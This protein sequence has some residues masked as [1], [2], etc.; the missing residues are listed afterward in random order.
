MISEKKKIGSLLAL[1]LVFFTGLML[2]SEASFD[3]GDG[4]QH[5]VVSRF[6][7]LH[8]YLFLDSWGKPFY[9]LVS[10]PFAQF[11][12]KGS[13][14]FN[15]LCG[16]GSSYFAYLF[17]KKMEL[18]N[19]WLIIPIVLF[20]PGFFPTL[21][22]GLTEPFFSFLLMACAYGYVLKKYALSSLLISFLPFIR[23][24]GF[25]IIPLFAITLLLRKQ[26][27]TIVLLSFGTI[28]YSLIG[29]IFLNDFFWIIYQNPYNGGS[30]EIYGHG[31]WWH[32]ISNYNYL[33]G[34]ILSILLLAG[35]PALLKS[36]M[37][38]KQ[39]QP[40]SK[41][42]FLTEEILLLICSFLVYLIAHSIMWWKG[43]ANS[44][45]MLRVIAAVL[46]CTSLL[47]LRGF[48]LFYI[49]QFKKIKI[50]KYAILFI[51]FAVIVITPFKKEYFPFNLTPEQKVTSEA[52]KWIKDS[53]YYQNKIYFLDP[54]L[55]SLLDIDSFD[56][57]RSAPLWGLYSSIEKYGIKNIPDSTVVFWDSHY[58]P[59]ECRIPL[60]QLLTDQNFKHLKSF[61]PNDRFTTLGGYEYEINVFMKL[62]Q[63]A[64]LV[65]L[66]E[67][68]INF[69]TINENI[70]G[71]IIDSSSNPG[72]KYF[73]IN[74]DNEF[75][76][77][78]KVPIN[79]IPYNTL[80]CRLKAKV[81]NP[82]NDSLKFIAVISVSSYH[83]I[84]YLWE[85]K[86][87]KFPKSDDNNY[88][89]PIDCTFNIIIQNFASDSNK[90]S[91]NIWNLNHQSYYIDDIELTFIGNK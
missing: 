51:S 88:W 59:N 30:R 18:E 72:N 89:Q 38:N 61:R 8:P 41:Q 71:G 31:E 40:I 77:T 46:P 57:L 10:S 13:I 24:E 37:Q 70:V 9:T 73:K 19:T 11:G 45:G 26:Y 68:K 85:G 60:T 80:Q 53:K 63:P 76:N 44:L 14:F 58:G 69:E 87:C 47:C 6:S 3:A 48:N 1:M 2:F 4:I 32:F 86:D 54:F 35:I 29:L 82:N 62:P 50:I 84:N 81:H 16:I 52:A 34:I 67:T 27:F 78:Y 20:A 39:N 42:T 55:S 28:F 22:S 7:W 5:Y 74:S 65:N 12:I 25:F 90:F 17:A 36:I 43:W 23:T 75:A 49:N 21:N 15:L 66:K 79:S 64:S 91:F 33:F 56:T 83:E